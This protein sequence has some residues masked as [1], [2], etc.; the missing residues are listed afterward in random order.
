MKVPH[1]FRAV[2]LLKVTGRIRTASIAHQK[3]TVTAVFVEY[4][5]FADVPIPVAIVAHAR[6]RGIQPV[7]PMDGLTDRCQIKADGKGKCDHQNMQHPRD[8]R[9]EYS[10]EYRAD[11]SVRNKLE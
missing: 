7:H 1:F 3:Q 4:S 11:R 6:R 10:G 2:D 9:E 8:D 5:R